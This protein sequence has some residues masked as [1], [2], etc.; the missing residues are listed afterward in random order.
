MK[1]KFSFL[2]IYFLFL[3]LGACSEDDQYGSTYDENNGNPQNSTADFTVTNQGV[4]AYVFSGSGL[5]NAQ[6]PTLS[7]VRGRSYTFDI[8]TSGHPFLIKSVAST[9]TNN[10][11]SDGVSGNGI[12]VGTITFTVPDDAP[13]LLFYV[14]EFHGSMAGSI[15]I[16]DPPDAND[17]GDYGDGY[18]G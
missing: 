2:I 15:N 1:N 14:C 7:F 18:E 12:E 3:L 13:N 5:S 4:S 8:N 9:G 17:S 10:L 16:T 6:N 11:F